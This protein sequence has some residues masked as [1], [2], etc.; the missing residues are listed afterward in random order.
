MLQDRYVQ[1]CLKEKYKDPNQS[2]IGNIKGRS[3]SAEN[4]LEHHLKS[5]KT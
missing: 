5:R 4:V 2:K 1:Q 3:S